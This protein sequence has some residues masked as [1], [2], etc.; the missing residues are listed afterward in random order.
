LEERKT[1]NFREQP[2][3]CGLPS[4]E[5]RKRRRNSLMEKHPSMERLE[6]LQHGKL[7]GAELLQILR[8][9][10]DCDACYQRM[11][12]QDPTAFVERILGNETDDTESEGDEIDLPN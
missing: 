11:P 6:L 5:N 4:A 9:L 1:T 2:T 10:E 3:N 12:P 8:H 7:R